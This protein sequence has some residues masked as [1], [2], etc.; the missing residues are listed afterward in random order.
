M[1]LRLRWRRS[2]ACTF[3][4]QTINDLQHANHHRLRHIRR[5]IE[6]ALQGSRAF[7]DLGSRHSPGHV[8]ATR[9]VALMRI[10]V[11]GRWREGW[12]I[13]FRQ[14]ALGF[15]MTSVT[16]KSSTYFPKPVVFRKASGGEEQGLTMPSSLAATNEHDKPRLDDTARQSCRPNTR[17][18]AVFSSARGDCASLR[19]G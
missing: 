7:H 17:P 16:A 11:L 3:L 4:T 18:C 13:I 14:R 15:R 8:D 9:A 1:N 5:D 10:V 2:G 19:F 12:R 6:L